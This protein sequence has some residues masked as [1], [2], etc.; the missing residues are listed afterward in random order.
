VQLKYDALSFA[1]TAQ[2]CGSC[3]AHG[4]L[5]A[6]ADRIKIARNHNDGVGG[7]DEINL[8]I[9]YVL[10][11]GSD[12]AGSCHGGS[13]TGVYQFIKKNGMIPYDSCQP[14]LACSSESKDGFCAHVDTTCS[15]MN[16]CRTCMGGTGECRAIERFPNATVAE[17]GTYS[18][19]TGGFGA[20]AN[21][22]KVSRVSLACIIL[23]HIK[24]IFWTWRLL[25]FS[26]HVQAE[27][28]ARG[29]RT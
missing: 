22:I 29:E 23:N 24:F 2:Y 13:H 18:Y 4:A 8:S 11:C 15:P 16:T 21:K 12:I 9:Q 10:N 25:I 19:F 7:G 28:Y 17:Y 6:L 5:S 14:Y 1:S 20:V 3:W 26:P 27:I